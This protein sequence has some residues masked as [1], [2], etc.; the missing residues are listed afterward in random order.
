MSV[1]PHSDVLHVNLS[2]VRSRSYKYRDFVAMLPMARANGWL[3]VVPMSGPHVYNVVG[4][5]HVA[6]PRPPMVI[7][8]TGFPVQVGPDSF[9]CTLDIHFG[10]IAL[11]PENGVVFEVTYE[12]RESGSVMIE[13][14]AFDFPGQLQDDPVHAISMF[15]LYASTKTT[16]HFVVR[17]ANSGFGRDLSVSS[18]V[19]VRSVKATFEPALA[20]D[21]T[22]Y[23]ICS[24]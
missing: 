24:S 15:V 4:D 12:D 20:S 7:R 16:F 3:P 6:P 2:G 5:Y 10:A 8:S 18:G 14:F 21:P 23:S 22:V 17:T 9:L 13:P 19:K 1:I 11:R